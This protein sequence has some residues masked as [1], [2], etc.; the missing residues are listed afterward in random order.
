M[1]LT[2]KE[3]VWEITGK[4][5]NGCTYCGSKEVWKQEID[6]TKIKRITDRIAEYPPEEIDV[7]GGDPLLVSYDVHKYIIEKLANTKCKILANPKSFKDSLKEQNLYI[8]GLYSH[9]GFSINTQEELNLFKDLLPSLKEIKY[10]II[11]NFNLTN[12]FIFTE[13]AEF[14]KEQ[15]VIWQIQFTMY[16][17]KDHN[18]EYQLALYNYPAAV[19]KLN[20]DIAKYPDLMMVFADN[21]NCG[22]CGAGLHT[23]GILS[24][25]DVIPCLSMRSWVDLSNKTPEGNLF[26]TSLKDIWFNGFKAN[27]FETFVCC[28]D[29]CNK[30]LLNFTKSEKSEKSEKSDG[31][32]DGYTYTVTEDGGLKVTLPKRYNVNTPQVTLYAVRTEPFDLFEQLKMNPFPYNNS[33]VLAYGVATPTTYAATNEGILGAVSKGLMGMAGSAGS[34]ASTGIT[35]ATNTPISFSMDAAQERKPLIDSHIEQ[36]VALGAKGET[37]SD[38]ITRLYKQVTEKNMGE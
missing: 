3:I 1:K 18:K 37:L 17:P 13:F 33:G 12:F 11:T 32:K 14:V 38:T 26:S 34:T 24:N 10:T 4:C 2:L 21:A 19:E 29:M 22:E 31:S 9:V 16:P 15:N 28:K 8:L 20:E 27:R 36:L 30:Q 23:L 25:G 35:G 5:K 6:E 7:S